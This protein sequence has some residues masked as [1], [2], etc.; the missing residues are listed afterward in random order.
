MCSDIKEERLK[1]VQKT[2]KSIQGVRDY[3]KILSNPDIQAVCVSV[4]ASLHYQVAKD[5]LAA[6]KHV[7]M[8]KP[9]TTDIEQARELKKLSEEKNLV[10]MVGHVFEYNDR[11]LKAREYIQEG[12]LGERI[13][14]LHSVRTNLGPLRDDVNVMWDLGTHDLSI[15]LFLLQ[16][17]PL[18]VSARGSAY[19]RPE[20]IDIA[21][22]TLHFP[23]N[24]EAHLRVSWLDP[25]KVREI[26]IVGSKRMALVD[27][28]NNSEPIRVYDKGITQQKFYDNFGTFQYMVRHGDIRIPTFAM[29]EPLK[30]QCQHFLECVFEQKCPRTDAEEAI[31]ILEIL[32]ACERSIQKGGT[33]VEITYSEDDK[34][35]AQR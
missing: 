32:M 17:R 21:F 10:L 26:T 25:R 14:Y 23:D 5:A 24:I 3:Q 31:R 20:L 16:S 13:Y 35:E 19:I 8:E 18:Y 1:Y 27:D 22:A 7:L 33:P 30:N 2:F 12:Y 9:M 11:I 28:L 6:G 34:E 15:F 29:T 4:P